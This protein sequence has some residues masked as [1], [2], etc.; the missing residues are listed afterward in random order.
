MD[1]IKK[2]EFKR[3]YVYITLKDNKILKFK[4]E[5]FHCPIGIQST[6]K[7]VQEGQEMTFEKGDFDG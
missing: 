6:N 5:I 3:K 1:K 2:I 4:K 7:S